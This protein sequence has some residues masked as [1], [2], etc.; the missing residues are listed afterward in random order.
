[1]R[2]V[3][4]DMA[5]VVRYL[6]FESCEILYLSKHQETVTDYSHD[7]GRSGLGSPAERCS[8]LAAPDELRPSHALRNVPGW[9]CLFPPLSLSLLFGLPR[10]SM[11]VQ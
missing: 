11:R 8:G 7:N 6:L 4:E 10:C 5:L 3:S 1:M 9:R 2:I